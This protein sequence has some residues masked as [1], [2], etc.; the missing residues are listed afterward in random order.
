MN[1]QSLNQAFTVNPYYVRVIY[2][3]H[4]VDVSVLNYTVEVGVDTVEKGHNLKWWS[5]RNQLVK[6]RNVTEE[7]RCTVKKFG[8]YQLMVS[9]ATYY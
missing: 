5:S 4:F 3:L 8:N 9:Q 7:H 2:G 1:E 6:C